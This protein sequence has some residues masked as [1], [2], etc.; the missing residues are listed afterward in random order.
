ME[1]LVDCE[2]SPAMGT[3]TI[4]GK[5]T[6]ILFFFFF[7]QAFG[8]MVCSV[9]GSQ[10]KEVFFSPTNGELTAHSA[11]FFLFITLWLFCCR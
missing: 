6:T 11:A 2:G 7:V 9:G 8:E 1:V 3:R 10:A 4:Q 5:W